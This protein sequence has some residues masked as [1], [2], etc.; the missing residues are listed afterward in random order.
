MKKKICISMGVILIA[1][2]VAG[3]I[4]NYAD[5]GRKVNKQAKVTGEDLNTIKNIIDN[6]I[7][8]EQ[9]TNLNI[10]K[11]INTIVNNGPNTSSNPFD[12]IKASQ[13][14]YDELLEQHKETFEYSIKDLIDS[15]AS[16]GLKSYIE[17]LLCS[18]INR[19]FKYDFESASDYLKNYKEFLTKDNS[20][21]NDYD[22]YALSL[23]E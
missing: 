22:K 7:D 13:Q 11:N 20:N 9:N 19:N 2:I 4:N 21:L 3:I 23:L 18:E 17:A 10:E 14:E 8:D 1:V 6:K 15:N 16:N 12:Y 5:S